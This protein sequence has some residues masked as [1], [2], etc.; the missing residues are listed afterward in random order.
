M[1]YKTEKI[2]DY[3]LGLL[4]RNRAFE[5]ALE[6][7]VYRFLR[8]RGTLEVIKLDLRA[9]PVKEPALAAL[10][11]THRQVVET[12]FLAADMGDGEMGLVYADGK[13]AGL[14]APRSVA[15][16]A[17]RLRDMTVEV[18]DAVTDIEL[19]E[20]LVAPLVRLGARELVAVAEVVSDHVGLLYVD[21]VLVKQLTPGRYAFV[22]ALRRIDVVTF[23]LRLQTLE[24]TGQEVLTK[25]RIGLRANVTA[26]Y[27]V[28]DPVKAVALTAD[29]RDFLYK[30]LQFALRQV[31]GTR[32]LEE[33]LG[34]KLGINAAVAE[35]L[36]P[37]LGD[38]GLQVPSVGV[39]DI[40]LPGDVRELMN[41]V[42]EAEKTAQANVIKRREETAAT[43]SLLNT[44]K[45]ME[46]NPILLRLKELEALEK[47]SEK[48][49]NVIVGNGMDG[50]LDDLVRIRP[51]KG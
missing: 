38:A 9:M 28:A 6:P 4:Y 27:R 16:Y 22:K 42:I 19:P 14:V 18:L 51:R 31:I 30:E 5:K 46:D 39:K 37:K 33:V 11:L 47:V 13:L 48:V 20:R 44:A 21:G 10:Y 50:V 26:V 2:A 17:R 40:I 34:D 43:R 49:G 24:V 36:L 25:D 23:D 29:L 32:T 8:G 35:L 12:H 7:G 45:L 15:F 41:R 3:E 1:V